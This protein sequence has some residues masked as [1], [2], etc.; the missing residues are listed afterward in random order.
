MRYFVVSPQQKD[1]EY[2][3]IRDAV[4]MT[5]KLEQVRAQ[6]FSSIHIVSPADGGVSFGG[7]DTKNHY[8]L[9]A[10]AGSMD[11]F[12]RLVRVAHSKGLAVTISYN[13]GYASTDRK[14]VV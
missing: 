10:D 5:A 6:G 1:R 9:R 14:S 4:P 12:R 13:L 3:N 11:D 8:A 2:L 7:L